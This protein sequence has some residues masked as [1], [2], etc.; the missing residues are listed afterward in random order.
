MPSIYEPAEDSYLMSETLKKQIPKLLKKNKELKFLEVGI[1]SGINLLTAKELGINVNN[2]F[3]CDIN[4]EAV[5]HCRKFGFNVINSDL[6]QNIKG[7]Y[8]LIIFNPPYL[9]KDKREPKNSQLATTGGK[10]GNEIIVKFLKQAKDYINEKGVI[11]LLVSSLTPE[12]NFK[13][14]GYKAK[15]LNEK[16]MFFERLFLFRLGKIR[17]S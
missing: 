5:N 17:Q 10:K 11:F 12:I 14:L 6:F 16:K 8:D 15:V 3:G 13:E 7:K 4:E 2:I 1:G 9:P